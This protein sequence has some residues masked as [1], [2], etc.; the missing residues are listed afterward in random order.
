MIFDASISLSEMPHLIKRIF[1]DRKRQTSEN[2]QRLHVPI[3][4]HAARLHVAGLRA[5][6]R[7]CE[8]VWIATELRRL[9]IKS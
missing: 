7:R 3:D 2:A 1:A 8:L 4:R 6:R 9:A 5:V